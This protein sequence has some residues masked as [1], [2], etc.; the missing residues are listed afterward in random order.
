MEN[1]TLP[2]TPRKARRDYTG[3]LVAGCGALMVLSGFAVIITALVIHEQQQFAEAMALNDATRVT[4]AAVQ[5]ALSPA[6]VM[7]ATWYGEAKRG[8]LTAS[9]V[10][11]SFV[12][13][14]KHWRFDPDDL[15]A[16]H[17]TLAFGTKLRVELDGK[18]TVVTVTDRGPEAWTGSDLDLSEEAARRIGM[19]KLGRALV[20]V[21]VIEG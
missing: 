2:Q 16:A 10:H 17:R 4:P 8:W 11:R 12:V 1:I 14:R 6:L 13:Q 18:P 5:E 19:L 15:T 7:T 20:T 9:G 3:L 21:R